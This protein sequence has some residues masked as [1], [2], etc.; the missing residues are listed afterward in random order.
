MFYILLC[1]VTAI[2]KISSVV[3]CL[4]LLCF[5]C[6]FGNALMIYQNESQL[7]RTSDQIVYGRIV[8]IKSAWNSQKTHIETTAQIL[9]D[10]AFVTDD[11][12]GINAGTII[13]VT[14]LGGT[15]G[16]ISE[17]VEDMPVFELNSDAFVYLE[18]TNSGKFTIHGLSDGIHP[19]S[20]EN[21]GPSKELKIASSAGTVAQFREEINKTLRG[22]PVEVHPPGGLSNSL[23]VSSAAPGPSI[24]SI[25]PSSASTG[26]DTII[27]ITGSG[28]GSSHVSNALVQFFYK[29]T[30]YDPSTGIF[31]YQYIGT[32]NTVSWTDTQI[33]V[34]VPVRASSGF[35]RIRTD[36]NV[37]SNLFPFAI[38]FSYGKTKWNASPTYYINPGSISGFSTAIQN[39][40]ATWNNAGSS[41]KLN[42]GG[43]S[44]Y[45]NPSAAD[46][47]NYVYVGS[48]S[49]FTAGTPAQ[50]SNW[51][52]TSNPERIIDC[53]TEFNPAVP[54]TT[55][56]SSGG[57]FNIEAVMTHEFGHWLH[58]EDLYGN[59][60]QLGIPGGYPSDASPEMKMMFNYHSDS[61]G[62]MNLK[63]LS[64][65]DIAGIR[66]IY[67]SGPT[68]TSI[69][70]NYGYNSTSV[71]ITNLAGSNFAD[72]AAV[73][74]T[75][76]GFT[77]ISATG[78]SVVSPIKITCTFPLS[79]AT[80]GQYNVVVKNPDGKE[81]I[82]SNGFTITHDP[83]TMT[84]QIGVFRPSTHMFYLDYNGNIVWN[85]AV[86]DRAYNFGITGDIPVSGDWNNDGISEIGV[87]RPSTHSFYLDY[88]GNGVWNGEIFDRAYNFGI[89]GDIPVS[90]DW[91]NDRISEIGVF[92]PSTHSFYL[93]YNGNGAWNG[94]VVDRAYNFGIAGDIPVSGDWNYD[95]ISEIGVFR[96]STNMFYMDYNGNGIWNGAVIDRACNFGTTGDIPVSGDWNING[97]SE[98]GG[99]RP[100]TQIFYLDYNGN[101]AWNGAVIDSAY[102]FGMS[103]DIPVLGTWA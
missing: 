50:T 78:V 66:W 68:V 5:L 31:Y 77:N 93:D 10:E 36:S 15:V 64:S 7:I 90:G 89:T 18:K 59:L 28:F 67:G 27:T 61:L 12:A 103:G 73:L 41:F 65:A 43:A 40:A 60:P 84:T 2:M 100:S 11:K 88:N 97:I 87:F 39:A 58:F 85:G 49:D 1:K 75:R 19:V 71:P 17:R 34:I 99:F 25:T 46:L 21:P 83:T 13:P 9:V 51:W 53:D 91:N 94:A 6:G 33:R 95:G 47:I 79:G 69:T 24:S 20:S 86:I 96:P 8:D 32:N 72:G 102:N 23:S 16:D 56:T 82:L 74:L 38:T 29:I 98:I 55:G 81:G 48:S 62:N 26:T 3:I 80:M 22:I 57:T 52:Y 101:G 63:T 70:P 76:N 37:D 44:S 14:I 54:W 45:T 30:S 35:V 4:V 92:R 42:Y